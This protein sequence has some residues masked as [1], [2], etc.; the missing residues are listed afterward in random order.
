MVLPPSPH[1]GASGSIGPVVLAGIEMKAA[2]T[3]P[4]V[5]AHCRQERL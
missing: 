2:H 3:N 1:T 5:G 4:Y